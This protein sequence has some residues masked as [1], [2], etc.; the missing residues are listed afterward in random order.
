MTPL[1]FETFNVTSGNR[2][3]YTACEE[4]AGLRYNGDAPV[5]LLGPGQCGKSH[6]LWS[7]VQRVRSRPG[8][9][10]LVLVLPT[11]FPEKVRALIHD[12]TPIQHDRD[13]VFLVDNL[14]RFSEHATE[15]EEVTRLFLE[16]GHYAV[17]ATNVHP[18]RLHTFSRGFRALLRRGG[19]INIEAAAAQAPAPPAD[20]GAADETLRH[21]LVQARTQA[22]DSQRAAAE[23]MHEVEALR[24]ERSVLQRRIA[25]AAEISGSHEDL[26]Q[27]AREAAVAAE[28]AESEQHRL[29][30][31]V[32]VLR[33]ELESNAS[34]AAGEV[35]R[36]LESMEAE[37]EAAK[38]CVIELEQ[39][40][41]ALAPMEDDLKWL[42]QELARAQEEADAALAE[43]VRLQAKVSSLSMQ[44]E[45]SE[46]LEAARAANARAGVLQGRI[47][48]LAQR[49]ETQRAAYDREE[50]VCRLVLDEF[51]STLEH[52]ECAVTGH[53]EASGD[54]AAMA[55][56]PS[57]AA[58]PALEEGEPM[59]DDAAAA[60]MATAREEQGR[61]STALASARNRLRALEGELENIRVER[62][63]QQAEMRLL[64]QAAAG[65]AAAATVQAG[66]IDQRI[67][68][69]EPA[70]AL[71]Q[72]GE[73]PMEDGG[74]PRDHLTELAARLETLRA[75]AQPLLHELAER[76]QDVGYPPREEAPRGGD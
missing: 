48:L 39:R 75:T 29:L 43:Q 42:R 18:D 46:A 13:A 70:L 10:D 31:E 61:L 17:L 38:A 35:R 34:L 37:R 32:R 6:L 50:S 54:G 62:A 51:L 63:H 26:E 19:L 4:V 15:L 57:P 53:G 28:V 71:T 3:A 64:R 65:R 49:V 66:E 2:A 21:A 5:V 73:L 56:I 41:A 25:E 74:G 23:L 67:G 47:A 16:N 30:E 8:Q 60:L 44:A 52:Y 68:M 76:T 55:G 59:D 27:R 45:D 7:I 24:Q 11:Q 33:A 1:T 40:V 72:Q 9:T 58:A 22:E 20:D 69:L 14:E 36:A 12:P